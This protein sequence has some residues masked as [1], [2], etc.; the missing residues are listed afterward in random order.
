MGLGITWVVF[1]IICVAGF[2][3]I[4]KI[5]DDIIVLGEVEILDDSFVFDLKDNIT[6]IPFREIKM[7]LLKPM[8]GVS[9]VPDTY[10]VYDC[11]IKTDDKLYSYQITRE[12]IV[13]GKLIAKNLMN[14]KA[15]DFVKF[16]E[17]QK[18][19]HRF[20]KRIN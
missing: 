7:I 16:L 19:N 18:I 13:N 2:I 15:F 4:H 10:K 17:K 12:E 11:Q 1:A 3:F 6:T 20:G 8:L 9:R 5:A 14:P